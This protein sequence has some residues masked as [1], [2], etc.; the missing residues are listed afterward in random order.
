LGGALETSNAL[1]VLVIV[2]S[3]LLNAG[4]FLPII[5]KAYFKVEVPRDKDDPYVAYDNH[6]E[7]PVAMVMALSFTALGTL[8]LFFVPDIPLALGR[9][10]VGG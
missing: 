4:Y 2:A 1:A 5:Y 6:R 9:A 7:A 8:V 10:L 3:T